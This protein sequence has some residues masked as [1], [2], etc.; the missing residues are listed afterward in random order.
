MKNLL[1]RFK[2]KIIE[3]LLPLP[4]FN[5]FNQ[6]FYSTLGVKGKGVFRIS[7]GVTVQGSYEFLELANQ[8]EINAGVFLLLKDRIVIGE[9]ST[10]A[11]Q[12]S[13]FTSA[14]PN[15]PHNRLALIYPKMT[16]PVVV[17]DNTW[18]GARATVLP[19]VTIGNFCVVAAG[20]MVTKDVADYTVVAGI[21]A[22][23]VKKLNPQDFE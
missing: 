20:S 3:F 18:I 16:A 7:S 4:L 5:K 13:I 15:G 12:V 21:P 14:N 9:N 17:G 2:R 10:L 23:P 11:Y 22:K 8:A 19:G 6:S 1:N